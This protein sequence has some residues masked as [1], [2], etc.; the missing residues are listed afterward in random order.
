MD[1]LRV[2]ARYVVRHAEDV[3]PVFERAVPGDPRPR[4]AIEAAWVFVN[5][6][7]R[8]KLQR[9]A[10]IDAHRAARSAPGE[11]ARLA[12]RCAG[13]A[14]SAAYLHPIAQVSQVGHILRS[15]ASAAHIGE[16]EDGGDT[17]TADILLERS[18]RRATPT[19]IDILSRYPLAAGGR[20]RVA[21]LMSTL[22]Q[23]LRQRANNPGT[24]Q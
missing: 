15:A 23:I 12:A 13:D 2:V 4:A 7:A 21:S 24:R 10:S 17:D 11:A 19:L 16:L 18:R 8:T 1:E 22:D 6:A 9:V 20:S 14:A 5:G 3:L